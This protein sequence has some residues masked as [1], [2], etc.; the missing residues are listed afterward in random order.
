[1]K[2]STREVFNFDNP[3]YKDYIG[4]IDK[5]IEDEI[6]LKVKYNAFNEPK[7]TVVIHPYYICESNSRWY[8][9]GYV[10]KVN[11]SDSP[12]LK[13]D[14]LDKINNLAL[15]RIYSISFNSHYE[16]INTEVDIEDV[17]ENS[18]GPSISNW[19]NPQIVDLEIKIHPSLQQH[20]RTMP[21]KYNTQQLENG[22]VFI[23]KQ[24]IVSNELYYTLRQYGN[25]I[26]VVAPNFIR[27]KMSTDSKKLFDLYNS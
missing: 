16:F 23:Y 1:M 12:F 5:A 21:L 7:S 11:E 17:L 10:S 24:T 6:P 8:L 25:M 19:E 15:D 27:T 3:K 9:I 4:I 18:F 22:D 13:F 2:I 26:E 14:R 20:F